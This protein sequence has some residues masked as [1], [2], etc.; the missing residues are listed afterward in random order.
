M[1]NP[2]LTV[3]TSKRRSLGGQKPS[4]MILYLNDETFVGEVGEHLA[5]E[6]REARE[7]GMP[8]VMLHQNDPEDGG[9]EVLPAAPPLPASEPPIAPLHPHP[10]LVS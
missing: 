1:F 7:A 8:I 9:C 6:V 2:G 10:Q 5:A 4:H 3:A